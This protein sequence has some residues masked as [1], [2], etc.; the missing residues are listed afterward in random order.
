MKNASNT[1]G[2]TPMM[3]QY[4]RIKADYPDMLLFYRMGDFY[5][6][7]FDDAKRVS[8]L[9]D[10]TLTA[11]G[12]SAGS[13]I[14]MAGVPYHA[15]EPYLARLVKQG[16]SVA[17]CEQIGDPATS[18]GPVEREVV[19]II[20]P[21]TITDE[22]LLEDRRD[23]L[24]VALW[25]TDEHIGIASADIASGR[26]YLSLL[27]ERELMDELACLQPAEILLAEDH[28]GSENITKLYTV[29]KQPGWRFDTERGHE[30]LCKQLGT[31]DLSGFGCAEMTTAIAAAGCLLDYLADTQR[32][33]LP[34]LQQLRLQQRHDHLLL[35]AATRRNLELESSM[36]GDEDK[37]LAAIMDKTA[38]PMGSRMFRRWLNRPLRDRTALNQR[39]ETIAE[40]LDSNRY[41]NLYQ[42]LNGIGDIER[43]LA[44]VALKSARP[45]DLSRLRDTLAL[46]PEL[47]KQLKQAHSARLKTL[48]ERIGKHPAT[49]KLL[50]KA[51]IE[52]PPMVV[53]DGGVI[54]EGYNKTL[55]ELRS[56]STNADDYLVKLEERERKRSGINT[57]KVNYNRVHGFYIEVSR[58]QSV[59]V[60]DDYIRRQTLKGSERYITPELKQHE[61]KVLSAR[62]RA[63]AL[64]KELYDQLLDKLVG[65]LSLLQ[66]TAEG[67]AELDVL[68]NLAE[69]ADTLML[70]KPE[71]VDKK[72][73]N[74][75][76]GRHPVVEQ[77]LDNRFVPNNIAL[78]NKT[79]TLIITGPNMGGKSTYMRQIALIT[80]LAHIG[81]Y[82]P[83]SKA[84]IGNIDRIFTR[85]GASDDLASGRSTFMVEMTETAN[86]LNNA[87]EDSLVLLDEIG[88]GTGTYDGLALAWACTEHL[89]KETRCFTLFATHYF[90][91]T[92]L[93]DSLAALTNVHLEAREYNDTIAFLYEVKP[94]PASESYGLQVAALAGVPNTI[95]RAAQQHLQQL[96]SAP[97]T[98]RQDSKIHIH[99]EHPIVDKIREINPDNLSPK[100]ALELFY[101]FQDMLRQTTEPASSK[102]TKE[103]H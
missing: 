75:Q 41:E 80:L 65:E 36:T 37:S 92:K 10:I 56:L 42:T 88:R 51:I 20:T 30:R 23:N 55:D 98:T 25:Q 85:I 2:H 81:S 66:T 83:A 31:H 54:R 62:E 39:Y 67:L 3:Q 34:H 15:V 79:H 40:L 33:A 91:L 44:R 95:I 14:P 84:T 7:F 48:S 99:L 68:T 86:I 82:V 103:P 72:I 11:R 16:E 13:P 96:E 32:A 19:R 57:L 59:N 64:E 26:I 52:T 28:A 100:Q 6:L 61:D 97:I 12:Q 38:T 87:T 90:E 29:C 50:D 93:A 73:L 9:L 45:R 1:S 58:A 78:D 94:G 47:Q 76:Q 89:V 21:G 71:L 77:L 102:K 5:E 43:I 49:H 46:L 4:L 18:K 70:S 69:R 101:R 24:L 22:A 17:I 60:P 35:D 8:R 74:I 63:L 53:R 27:H